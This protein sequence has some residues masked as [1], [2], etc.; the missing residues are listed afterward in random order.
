MGTTSGGGVMAGAGAIVIV[1][2]RSGTKTPKTFRTPRRAGLNRSTHHLLMLTSS[3]DGWRAW[4]LKPSQIRIESRA[5]HE[6]FTSE[7]G[8]AQATTQRGEMVSTA[9]AKGADFKSLTA[10]VLSS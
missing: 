7:L 5:R 3:G 2:W 10:R 9:E 8:A 6:H 1:P 4:P